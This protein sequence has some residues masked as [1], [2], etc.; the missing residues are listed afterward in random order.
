MPSKTFYNL[1]K[2]KKE[3]LIKFAM[4]EFSN[5]RYPNVSINQIIRGAEIS[6]GSFYMYF[7]DKDDLF[8]YLVQL[9][10][11]K[12]NKIVKDHLIINKGNLEKAFIS[13]YDD[14]I[15]KIESFQYIG[16]F[17][18]VFMFFNLNKEHFEY[19][20]HILYTEVENLIRFEN[21]RDLNQEF[22]FHMF[23][24]NLFSSLALAL[25]SKNDPKNREIYMKKLDI[26]CHGIYKK[27][28]IL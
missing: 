1:G 22:I 17:R 25:K 16:F 2:E 8:L 21:I 18:N 24:Q 3:K 14:L 28:E 9:H 26:L 10:T 5:T 12:L 19:P 6:R 13:I 11:S 7:K 23:I 27:E 4:K 15:K 20:G